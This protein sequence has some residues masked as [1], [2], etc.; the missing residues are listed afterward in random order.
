VV[1]DGL[2]GNIVL[3]LLEGTTEVF[4]SEIKNKIKESFLTR[5]AGAVLAP[6]LLDLK[7]KLDYEEYGGA[8]LLGLNGVCIISHGKSKAKAIKN[9]IRVAKRMVLNNVVME[10]KEEI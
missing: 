4:F 2:T 3:K 8:P 10:I 1:C 7:K 9:A 6:G 5:M